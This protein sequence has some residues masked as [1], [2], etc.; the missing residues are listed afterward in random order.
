[1]PRKRGGAPADRFFLTGGSVRNELAQTFDARCVAENQDL[2]TVPT[3]G[4]GDVTNARDGRELREHRGKK[5]RSECS[6]T[7]E[8]NGE[9]ASAC[10]HLLL[11]ASLPRPV[12]EERRL[13]SD[14]CRA[15]ENEVIQLAIPQ[16][17]SGMERRRAMDLDVVDRDACSARAEL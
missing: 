4:A 16:D 13:P 8:E 5:L 10:R 15:W 1:M 9:R 17:I 7:S 11:Q 3:E 12:F 6:R 14:R 2:Q